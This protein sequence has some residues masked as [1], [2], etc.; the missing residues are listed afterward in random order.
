MPL[1]PLSPKGLQRGGEWLKAAMQII[2]GMNPLRESLQEDPEGIKQI[3]ISSGKKGPA[4]E[5]ILAIA[6]HQG[7]PVLYHNQSHLDRLTGHAVH[8]GIVGLC[9]EHVYASL[10]DIMKNRHPEMN[11]DVVLLL[12][13]ITDPQNLGA[14]IRTAHCFGANGVIIPAHRAAAVTPVVMKSSAGALRHIPV[15]MTV[16]LAQ[17]IDCLKE[18]QY[19]IY[20]ADTHAG[21]GMD[22]MAFE[23]RIG[24]VMG[25]EGK[26]IRPLIKK[27][28][29]FLFSV[30]MVGKIDSLNVSVATGIILHSIFGF[31][32]R[33]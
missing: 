20:G 21:L 2:Y 8:Q 23:G 17:A 25:S 5:E 28:C 10:D 12:D 9:R 31:L 19:W 29:D 16:N 30:P 6:S 33:R 4:I 27:K 32:N 26:G 22:A 24:L 14:L 18:N 13:E 1:S 7:I 3:I 15:A 11:G